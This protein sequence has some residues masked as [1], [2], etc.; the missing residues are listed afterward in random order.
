MEEHPF[1]IQKRISPGK[2]SILAYSILDPYHSIPNLTH[3]TAH[4]RSRIPVARGV[5]GPRRRRLEGDVAGLDDDRGG[6]VGEL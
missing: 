6:A 1:A 2:V 3:P 4:H 5:C